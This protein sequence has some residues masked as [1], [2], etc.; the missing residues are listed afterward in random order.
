MN[1]IKKYL[2]LVAGG[3]GLRMGNAI[4]KQFLPLHGIPLLTHSIIAFLQAIPDIELILVLPAGQMSYAQMVLSPLPSPVNVTI[5][6]GGETR[7][8]S[9]KNGLSAING[10]GVI[11]VHDGARPLVS[12][13]LILRCYEQA[14]ATGSAIPAINVTESMRIVNGDSST[15]VNRDNLRVI[16]TPQTFLTHIILPAFQQE[17]SPFFTDEATVAEANGAAI[18]LVEGDRRNIKVTTPEDIMIAGVFLNTHEEE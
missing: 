5:V 1:E 6:A 18:N 9:V 17:Y 7:F 13:Q 11:F 12:K 4:P 15:A 8:H 3:K 2:V 14:M 16:Q 10:Q